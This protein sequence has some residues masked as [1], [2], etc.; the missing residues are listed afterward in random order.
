MPIFRFD[1]SLDHTSRGA[2]YI[3]SLVAQAG[4]SLDVV[5]EGL[6][7]C[8][9][10]GRYRYSLFERSTKDSEDRLMIA[11][12]Y[13]VPAEPAAPAAAAAEKKTPG[14]SRMSK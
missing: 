14:P 1:A 3:V 11:S 10:P 12:S 6:S 2:P 4:R 8:R 5:N 9:R 13:D 7:M